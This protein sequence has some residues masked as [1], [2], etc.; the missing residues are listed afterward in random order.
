[1]R[2]SLRTCQLPGVQCTVLTDNRN[3]LPGVTL[4]IY[5]DCGVFD[6]NV[7]S[8]SVSAALLPQNFLLL[9]TLLSAMQGLARQNL[10]YLEKIFHENN[11]IHQSNF[12][13]LRSNFVFNLKKIPSTGKL[14][15]IQFLID[16]KKTKILHQ[17]PSKSPCFLSI[18]GFSR[19]G[20]RLVVF[21]P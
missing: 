20:D 1:M 6:Q 15:M 8:Q 21:N 12:L 5:F 3:I 16:C 19:G 14:S 13:H 11:F 18:F 4:S 7:Q 10:L 9:Q 2:L 17:R